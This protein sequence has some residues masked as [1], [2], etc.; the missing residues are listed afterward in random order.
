MGMR[1]SRAGNLEQRSCGKKCLERQGGE[2]EDLGGVGGRG[3]CVG[4]GQDEGW[5]HKGDY[6][7]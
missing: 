4:G 6:R 7:E 1:G 5:A 2:W 3:D